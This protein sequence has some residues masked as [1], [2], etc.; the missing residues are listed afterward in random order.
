[1]HETWIARQLI[2]VRHAPASVHADTL[3]D[4]PL[5]RIS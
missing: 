1:M 5:R 2:V 3:V 4:D